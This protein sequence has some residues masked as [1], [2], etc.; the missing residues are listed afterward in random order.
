VRLRRAADSRDYLG[1]V[2]DGYL[3]VAPGCITGPGDLAIHAAIF[4]RRGFVVTGLE[5][6]RP[7]TLCLYGSL[8]AGTLSATEPR[9]ATKL[10]Y[11]ARFDARRP[12]G[13]PATNRF[14]LES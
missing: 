12:P 4:A 9:D 11:D 7:A 10:E 14:V 2:S 6:P 5:Y 3:H 1:I 13:F 8:T